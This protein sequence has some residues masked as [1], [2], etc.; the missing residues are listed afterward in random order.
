M[1]QY[2][3]SIRADVKAT[4][5]GAVLHSISGLASPSWEN[6][7]NQAGKWSFVVAMTT[8][9]SEHWTLGKYVFV[10]DTTGADELLFAGKIEDIDHDFNHEKAGEVVKISG[11]NM[12]TELREGEIAEGEIS[13]RA[14]RT[15]HHFE[16]AVQG[17]PV[18]NV[19]PNALSEE[20]DEWANVRLN[21]HGDGGDEF[22]GDEFIFEH[23]A[24]F[25]GIQLNIRETDGGWIYQQTN[26]AE[27]KIA[28]I[29]GS[30]WEEIDP[31]SDTTNDSGR[32]FYIFG[33]GE[34]HWDAAALPMQ[35]ETHA[36]TYGY[37]VRLWTN[38]ELGLNRFGFNSLKVYEAVRNTNDLTQLLDDYFPAG[39]SLATGS[40]TGT[41]EG[42]L[43]PIRGETPLAVALEIAERSGY[44]FILVGVDQIKWL[45]GT[46]AS[47][48]TGKT[49]YSAEDN[50]ATT[51]YITQMSRRKESRNLVTRIYPRGAGS[52]EGS[53]L[54]ISLYETGDVTLAGGISV[55]PLNNLIVNT[56]LEAT[57][58]RE[59]LKV[60]DFPALT[61]PGN[62]TGTTRETAAELVKA[63]QA[64]LLKNAAESEHWSITAVNVPAGLTPGM[65]VFISATIKNESGG[66]DETIAQDLVVTG[67]KTSLDSNGF[68]IYR[69]EVSNTGE[70]PP[71]Q[72]RLLLEKARID[73]KR[74]S[75][76]Q[77]SS[78]NKL[79]GNT[80]SL[81]FGSSGTGG[82][83]VAAD[84]ELHMAETTTAHG[85]PTQIDSKIATHAALENAHHAKQ[86]GLDDAGHHTGLLP[87]AWLSKMGSSLADLTTRAYSDLTGR[88]HSITGSD[89][90]IGGSSGDVVGNTGS[91]TPGLITPVHDGHTTP[92]KILKTD[93]NG[94]LILR[95]LEIDEGLIV[96]AGVDI[97][98]EIY[99]AGTTGGGSGVLNSQGNRIGI[100]CIPDAQF[101]LDISGSLRVSDYIVG[102]MALQVE[103]A[104]A[105]FHMDGVT[106]GHMGQAG[107]DTAIIY[108][109][110]KFSPGRA[111]FP[112]PAL[113]NR[114]LNPRF[115]GTYASGIAPNVYAYAAGSGAGTRSEETTLFKFGSKAQRINRTSGSG[116]STDRYGVYSAPTGGGGTKT[117]LSAWVFVSSYTA[118]AVIRLRADN[119]GGPGSAYVQNAV[120]ITADMV[121]KWSKITA[122]DTSHTATSGGITLYLWIET[123]N[124]NIVVDGLSLI[125]GI[126]YDVP[127]FSGADEGA[128]WSGTAEASTSVKAAGNVSYLTET[129]GITP[130]VGSIMAW[131]KL[132]EPNTVSQK[133]IATIYTSLGDYLYLYI[134][135]ASNTL[136]GSISTNSVNA[137]IGTLTGAD[138]VHV[139]FTWE[140]GQY[141]K[142]YING[143]ET[144]GGTLLS[145]TFTLPTTVYIGSNQSN[146]NNFNGLIDELAFIDRVVPVSEII[147]IYESGAPIFAPTSAHEFAA[148]PTQTIWANENGLYGRDEDGNAVLGVATRD[149]VSWAGGT[150]NKGDMLIGKFTGNYL[151][152]DNGNGTNSLL[153]INALIDE[154]IIGDNDVILREDEGIALKSSPSSAPDYYEPSIISFKEGSTIRSRIWGYGYTQ[155][156]NDYAGLGLQAARDGVYAQIDLI[157]QPDDSVT[158][159]INAT[160][161]VMAISSNLRVGNAIFLGATDPSQQYTIGLTERTSDPSSPPSNTAYIYLHDASGTNTLRVKFANGTVRTLATH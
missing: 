147:S 131:I 61:A 154:L 155:L 42:T 47:G 113:T 26:E 2:V 138:W 111:I 112:A 122:T 13:T 48:Y 109:E 32:P 25:T 133:Q 34:I 142:L 137:N 148:G 157:A 87:W 141:L 102:K 124:A 9:R 156:S 158:S 51:F 96:G 71:T 93:S 116:T 135:G 36:G 100:N 14:W 108:D 127:T 83:D 101:A 146:A 126:D 110:G 80:G 57:L 117:T 145:T 140:V 38:S 94:L 7:L 81:Q 45:A 119:A 3:K 118:G 56:T 40:E 136:Y 97:L 134:T 52:D 121:G 17:S 24:P 6:E 28:L 90:S 98:G 153:K 55:L 123:Q 39:W 19:Q 79:V 76:P 22:V 89:H 78:I 66:T 130:A 107:T 99:I 58:G 128:T 161:A 65:T 104:T 160:A 54:N 12:L 74:A 82:G 50:A 31:T 69:L 4:K 151:F 21:Q 75:Y 46:P 67:I 92:N 144:V 20:P 105:I 41:A 63:G 29:N 152:W 73:K 18:H 84:L 68:K 149:N 132:A 27:I 33:V 159:R 53:F 16:Q 120:T 60:I 8:F 64:F 115:M 125:E 88:T 95:S 37:V 77:P 43:Y 139:A 11:L 62:G 106:T 91:G 129:M 10:Y 35:S 30:T 72:E 15:P 5:Y 1:A 70:H 150:L 86:H 85:I 49:Q 103:G 23:D 143:V 44:N 59:I 114:V